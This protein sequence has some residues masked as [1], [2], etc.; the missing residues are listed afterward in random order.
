MT[1]DNINMLSSS[2]SS[3]A[4]S[5]SSIS[6]NPT[7]R[8]LR[9]LAPADMSSPPTLSISPLGFIHVLEFYPTEGELDVPVSVRIHFDYHTPQDVY[10]RLVF[11][12]TTS[13]ATNVREL[14]DLSYGRWMLEAAAPALD[15]F[16]PGSAVRVRVQAVTKD[17]TVLDTAM[18]GDFTYWAEG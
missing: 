16:T 7:P 11:G 17:D 8:S 6:L 15:A 5:L 14:P 2:P 1:L 18:V 4:S 3:L 10:L 9:H 12:E 13:V